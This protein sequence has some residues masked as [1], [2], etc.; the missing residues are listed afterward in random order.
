[1]SSLT[2]SELKSIEIEISVLSIL[3]RVD[4]ADKIELG[5]HGVLVRKGYHSGVFLPQVATET[6]WSKEEF[7]RNL[8]AHKAGLAPDAWKDKG[9][10]LYNFSAEVFSEKGQVK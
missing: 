8:C 4:S 5:K 1:F 9:T 10:E 7:L 2:L 6:G 3:E